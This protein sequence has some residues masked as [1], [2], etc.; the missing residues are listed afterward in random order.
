[1]YPAP[2]YGPGAAGGGGGA[3]VPVAPAPMGAGG[4][5]VVP[6]AVPTDILSALGP[7]RGV[8]VKQNIELLEALSGGMCET[9]NSYRLYTWDPERGRETPREGRGVEFAEAREISSCLMRQ[10]C[11]PAREFNMNV[12]LVLPPGVAAANPMPL[13]L[14]R[15]FMCTC[16]PFCRSRIHICWGEACISEVY[17]PYQLCD[18]KLTISTP[19]T[20]PGATHPEVAALG[21]QDWFE[22]DGACCQPGMFCVC[23]CAP[24]NRVEFQIRRPHSDAV[25][26]SMA[27]VWSGCVREAF[28]DADVFTVE[29]PADATP[30]QKAS[31]LASV[32]LFDFLIFEKKRQNNHNHSASVSF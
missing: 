20:F 6:L 28:T 29:F 27:K 13:V 11:G 19:R 7:L 1:M 22:V 9:P 15:P 5:V 21:D 14:R 3:V 4:T 25:V 24:C 12:S 10:C 23:P 18:E 16:G 2:G 31:L 8:Y 32:L 26:G 17:N 30:V